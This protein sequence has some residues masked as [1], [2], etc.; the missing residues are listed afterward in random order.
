MSF[1]IYD[2]DS[3]HLVLNSRNPI[4][5][6][7]KKGIAFIL[8]VIF[9]LQTFYTSAFTVWF[10][11][12]RKAIAKEHCINKN[13]PELKCDGK[14]FLNRK[15]REASQH[16]DEE[17]P[18]HVKQQLESSPFTPADDEEATTT[19]IAETTS[20]HTVFLNHYSYLHSNAVFHP[21]LH[22]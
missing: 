9:T 19:V 17:A 1:I 20:L 13:R 5:A 11:A 8:L 2:P 21:P 22:S 12:N 10:Y 6:P 16:E 4:F 15:M 7:V 18:L 3:P 14:C